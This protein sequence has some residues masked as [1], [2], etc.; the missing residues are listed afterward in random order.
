MGHARILLLEVLEQYCKGPFKN[1]V[2]LRGEG[3]FA[4]TLLSG[5]ASMKCYV[6][7]S[8]NK[9]LIK[10]FTNVLLNHF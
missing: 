8:V 6:T 1:Y 4:K 2:T 3:G 10:K 9:Y 7:K 5:G